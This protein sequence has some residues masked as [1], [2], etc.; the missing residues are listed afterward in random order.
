MGQCCIQQRNYDPSNITYVSLDTM[1]FIDSNEMINK[2]GHS[3]DKELPKQYENI[4]NSM[5]EK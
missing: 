2:S 4:F 1:E 3:L 5:P